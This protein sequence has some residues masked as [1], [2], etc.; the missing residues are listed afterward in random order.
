MV[1]ARDDDMMMINGRKTEQHFQMLL[2]PCLLAGDEPY[3]VCMSHIHIEP[4]PPRGKEKKER[5]NRPAREKS[6]R[7]REQDSGGIRRRTKRR[8]H[9]HLLSRHEI[10]RSNFSVVITDDS[11]LFRGISC[12]EI[13]K[14][15]PVREPR[16]ELERKTVVF[17]A[18]LFLAAV[19][20]EI[21]IVNFFRPPGLFLKSASLSNALLRPI[22]QQ[23]P[24]SFPV[25]HRVHHFIKRSL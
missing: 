24:E 9:Y 6:P 2:V 7:I 3:H 22:K 5:K 8:D 13:A 16:A 18:D 14:E 4:T 25:L 10:G 15:V 21:L 17:F 1:T 11:D 20:A 19:V 12:A 23:A